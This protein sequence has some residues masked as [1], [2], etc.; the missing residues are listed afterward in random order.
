MMKIKLNLLIPLMLFATIGIFIFQVNWLRS[1][2]QISKEKITLEVDE[3]LNAAIFEHKKLVG[4]TIRQILK[5]LIKSDNDIDY[6][7]ETYT[8]KV[9]K[10]QIIIWY[11]NNRLPKDNSWSASYS[12]TKNFNQVK[13]NPYRF[14]CDKLNSMEDFDQLMGLASGFLLDYRINY[15]ENSE[16]DKMQKKIISYREGLQSD[17]L[18]LNRILNKKLKGN[19]VFLSSSIKYFKSLSEI[20]DK[21]QIKG[22]NQNG[23]DASSQIIEVP[24]NNTKATPDSKIDS[25]YSYIK[26]LNK[27]SDTIYLAKPIINWNPDVYNNIPTILVA[28][29]IPKSVIYKD[30]S[31][32]IVSS[33]ILILLVG[34]CLLYM[35]YLI[36]Q[37]KKLAEIKDDFISN[38]SHELKTPV[39]TSLAAIHGLQYFEILKDKNKTDQYLETAAKEMKRLSVMIDNILN[40]VVYERS[41]FKVSPADFNLKTMLAEII[42]MHEMHSKSKPHFTLTY[43]SA[44]TIFGDRTHLYQVFSNLIDNAIKYGKEEIRIS[45]LC[46]KTDLG[47]RIQISDNGIGIPKE[48]QPYIFDKF[49]RVPKPN[50]H[51]VKGH[52]LGLSYVKHIIDRHRGKVNLIKSDDNGSIFE[53]NLPQ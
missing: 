14:F 4:D 8:D 2:Y 42:T 12:V 3:N 5:T 41:G 19:I 43:S 7:F 53:I 15:P 18:S 20:L 27:S 17:T 33:I 13:E 49:F 34:F 16:G 32:S 48:Y 50:D 30:M 52:G 35:F 36:M 11:R 24:I 39:A 9:G 1:S 10:N 6:K 23:Q 40:S 21:K 47:T 44:E 22:N 26:S 45:V 25:L 46:E 31:S 28:V 29:K 51:S 38:I 37:Q